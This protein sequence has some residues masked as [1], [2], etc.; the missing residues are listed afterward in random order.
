MRSGPLAH[1][2][3][4]TRRMIVP[5]EGRPATASSITLAAPA[6]CIG[7]DRQPH[8][9]RGFANPQGSLGTAAGITERRPGHGQDAVLEDATT[10]GP[11]AVS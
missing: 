2:T 11:L 6:P 8:R 4:K 9:R 1:F 5:T 10:S 7:D 3:H